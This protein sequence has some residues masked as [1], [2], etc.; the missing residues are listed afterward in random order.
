VGVSNCTTGSS[1]GKLG[2]RGVKG[3]E[4]KGLALGRDREESYTT[5]ND[6]PDSE[7]TYFDTLTRS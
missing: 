3:L 7:R 5:W 4:R 2:E 6:N 1:L